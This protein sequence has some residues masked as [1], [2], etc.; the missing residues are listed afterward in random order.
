MRRLERG[1]GLF[2]ATLALG[3]STLAA[4]AEE[5]LLRHRAAI[6]VEQPGAFVRLPLP[7]SAY[8]HSQQP[9]LQD[10]RVVDARGERVPF[11]LLAPRPDEAQV[12]E[13]LRPAAL[14]ALPPRPATGADWAAPLE[15]TV[16]AGRISVR[17]RPGPAPATQPPGW[18]VDLGERRRDAPAP[19]SLRLRW[20]EG[21]EFSVGVAVETSDDLRAWRRAG[22]SQVMA[23]ASAA[24]AL[25]QPTVPLPS[26]PGRFVRLVWADPAAA[27]RLAG[28]D[29]VTVTRRQV[30]LDAPVAL[31]VAAR[32]ALA[33][34][35]EELPRGT[36]EFDLGAALP[37]VQ[38]E[39]DA[40]PG[41][42]VV[43]ARLQGRVRADEPWQALGGA[44][45][46]RIERDAAAERSPPLTLV[47]RLR[48][49]RVLPDAR[50]GAL[51]VARTRLQIQAQL[52]ALVFAAQGEPPYAL[53][54]GS[55]SASA[56]ALPLATLVPALEDERPRFGRARL[57]D[58]QEDAE[59]VRQ[60]EAAQRL[61]ALR[62]WLLWGVLV[63]G[64]ALLALLVWRL[65][66]EPP[67]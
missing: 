3:L 25:T 49:L 24:G 31:S 55:A 62:P 21:A 8:A 20:P 36:L 2:A 43:P 19:Q 26:E 4:A 57:G 32:A 41:T 64:V 34:P 46:Y 38:I 35:D 11:A 47:R 16:E 50:A 13:Q 15:L 37:I 63:G 12:D 14:Y 65:T 17:P 33:G 56:G 18:L 39:L 27:P 22:R 61:A 40:G 9:G 54:A 30:T 44:V 58:W 45:F 59:A 51:D 29:A 42:R 6:E 28:A 52:S 48:H 67:T 23:L 53:L 10:L 7:V 5:P 60:A 66:R 1:A